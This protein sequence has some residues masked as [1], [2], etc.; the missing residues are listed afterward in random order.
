MNPKFG[1]DDNEFVL[2]ALGSTPSASDLKAFAEQHLN[3]VNLSP[4]D[5][6]KEYEYV[7]TLNSYDEQDDFYN[8][9]EGTGGR[10]FVPERRIQCLDRMPLCRSTCYSMTPVEAAF[11][12]NDSR[13]IAVELSAKEVGVKPRPLNYQ[14]S[15]FWDKSS[16][17]SDQMKN[18][19]LYRC[20][21]RQQVSGWGSNGTANQSGGLTTTSTGLNVDCVVFDGNILPGHPE[22]AKNSNGSGGSRV[23]QINWWAYNPSVT[24]NPAGTYNY[25][26]GTAGD[27]GH[28]MHVAG[29]MAGNTQ[30]WARNSNIYNISPYG[31]QTNG[32]VTPSLTQL[33]NYIRYWHN[34]VKTINPATGRKNPTVVNMSFGTLF[35]NFAA[36]SGTPVI[37]QLFY[38]GVTQNYPAS[39]PAGQTSLQAT[40]NGNWTVTRWYNA[41]V[42]MFKAYID[43]Y[44][45]ILWYGT[46]QDTAAQQAILD[47]AD[48]GIIWVSA[49]GNNFNE[50]FYQSN[51]PNYNNYVRN[52]PG[53]PIYHNRASAPQNAQS[54]TPG[55]ANYKEIAVIGNIG[56]LTNEQLSETSCAGNKVTAWAP[57]ENIMSAYNSPGVSDPRNPSYYLNKLSGTSMASPQVAGIVA[58]VA[59]N[60]PNMTQKQSISYI[61]NFVQRNIVP[62]LGI[63]LPPGPV[64][65]YGLRS[66][67]NYFLNYYNDRPITGNAWPQK[68]FWLRPSSG[69]VYPRPNLQYRPIAT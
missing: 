40:Y 23:N 64:S 16:A 48:E 69:A 9:M 30:G 26:A 28:G 20:W 14:F 38:R 4:V 41:G 17:L 2:S 52:G 27:N 51:H 10:G 68:R 18:W 7:V 62:D 65:Y 60:Y 54:G 49:A 35:S 39:P 24:G 25:S 6:T 3:L 11:L 63:P 57:G 21:L 42:Q 44:G 36:S 56:T 15:S 66:A 22:Y 50:A 45:I 5:P 8:E 33:V 29:I 58:C 31:E 32:Y 59:E 53:N 46:F 13:V 12:E 55:T 34:N 1:V 67:P 37:D 43:L 47:G 19:A 61:A